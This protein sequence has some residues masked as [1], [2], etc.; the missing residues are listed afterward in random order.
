[1]PDF[2]SNIN[3]T[4]ISTQIFTIHLS[5]YLETILNIPPFKTEQPILVWG[6]VW[7]KQTLQTIRPKAIYHNQNP[8]ACK[9]SRG[10]VFPLH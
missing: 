3:S 9:F 10:K 2:E 8:F 5:G 1:M 4:D 7:E 6:E